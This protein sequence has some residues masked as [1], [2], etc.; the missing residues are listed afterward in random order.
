MGRYS[1]GILGNFSGKVGT[2]IGSHWKG[3]DYM[4]SLPRKSGKAPTESQMS[5]HLKF[6]LA[7]NF[8][9]PIS[10][11]V[12][13]GFGNYAKQRVSGYNLAVQYTMKN[14]ITGT[15][16]DYELD[17]TKLLIS[18]GPVAPA[19]DP[20]AESSA[21]G[22]LTISWTDNTSHEENAHTDDKLMF[23]VYNPA[24]A[25]YIFQRGGVTRGSESQDVVV[26]LNFSGDEVE[27]Y[28]AFISRDGKKVS[29][30]EYVGKAL[31]A[32]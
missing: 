22:S 10:V 19:M 7:V 21:A 32:S 3:I 26:P 14:A 13:T 25:R 4:R 30:S 17:Y 6:A 28:V 5:Q 20:L 1:R 8:N 2:V 24:K 9:K 16:P 29:N 18:V 15:F 12:N 31:I 23:L 11:L 27:V